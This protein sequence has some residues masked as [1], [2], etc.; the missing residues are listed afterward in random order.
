M[1]TGDNQN[2]SSV[3]GQRSS[4][5]VLVERA[6]DTASQLTGYRDQQHRRVRFSEAFPLLEHWTAM[7]LRSVLVPRMLLEAFWLRF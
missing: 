5:S 7:L 4:N 3:L 2:H 6:G 1:L